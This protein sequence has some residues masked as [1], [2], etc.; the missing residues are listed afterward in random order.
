MS[1]GIGTQESRDGSP[2]QKLGSKSNDWMLTSAQEK[3]RRICIEL[4]QP[5]ASAASGILTRLRLRVRECNSVSL[6]DDIVASHETNIFFTLFRRAV[7]GWAVS[8]LPISAALVVGIGYSLMRL[9]VMGWAVSDPPA[10]T[11]FEGYRRCSL[12]NIEGCAWILAETGYAGRDGRAE[13]A[14]LGEL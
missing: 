7:V 8:G 12:V 11:A 2:Q 10:N 6:L 13:E 9:A 14:I 1:A 3:K 4:A 5:K